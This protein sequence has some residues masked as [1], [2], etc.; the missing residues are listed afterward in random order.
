MESQDSPNPISPWKKAVAFLSGGDPRWPLA[1]RL[2]V[3][4]ALVLAIGAANAWVSIEGVQRVAEDNAQVMRAHQA[5]SEIQGML[6]AILGMETANRGYAITGH[7]EF[8]VAIQK[9]EADTTKRLEILKSTLRDSPGEQR[10][11]RDL[12]SLLARKTAFMDDTVRLRNSRGREAAL[13]FITQG[14]G[15]QLMDDTRGL[16]GEMQ[17][18]QEEL[19]G[20]RIEHSRHG[21]SVIRG[22]FLLLDLAIFLFLCVMIYLMTGDL[23]RQEEMSRMK[24]AFL[25][26]MSHEL[27]TPLNAIIGFSELMYNGKAGAVSAEH[28]E[29][30]GDILASSRHLLQLINDILDLSKIE[31]GKMRFEAETVDLSAMADEVVDIL[32]S[33][34]AQKRLR[35]E[36]RVDPAAS[37]AFLDAAK[38]KQVLYNYLSNAIK[39][40]GEGGRI[41]VRILPETG[42]L[43][44]LEVEDN[45]IGIKSEDIPRLFVEFQQLDSSWAKKHAGTGLGLALV[46]RLVE[47]QGG[48]VGVKSEPGKGSI[49]FALFPKEVVA[50]PRSALGK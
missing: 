39:F 28:K 3:S 22:A 10:N 19:L 29:Y 33:L 12:E 16:L 2:W 41:Q 14:E 48:E 43:I 18:R 17:A 45:G 23:V 44:R 24:N 26:N 30:L 7:K 4:F 42:E 15:P 47:M 37:S 13:G 49:F 46:K 8:S 34:A 20:A 35:V 40:T 27:R 25:A 32:R 21:I 6:V 31:S 11:L 50:V 1:R 36:T 9:G 5:V 38:F